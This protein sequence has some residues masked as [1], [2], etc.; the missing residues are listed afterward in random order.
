[1][2]NYF[3]NSDIRFN[4]AFL[5]NLKDKTIQFRHLIIILVLL[6]IIAFVLFS[7]RE[8][9]FTIKGE[10]ETLSI[11]LSTDSINQW[12]VSNAQIVTDILSSDSNKTIL[13]LDSY[14]FPSKN[15]VARLQVIQSES[16]PYFLITLN[17]ETATSVGKIETSLGVTK[18]PDYVELKIPINSP[19]TL[20]FKG[21]VRIGE[22]VGVGVDKILLSGGVRIIEKQLFKDNRY[23]AGE[24]EFD[25]GDKL[26]L[27]LDYEESILAS[28]TGFIR[29][30][31]SNVINF[32]VQGEGK[33]LKVNKLGSEGYQI[34]S[35]IWARI[36]KDPI[37]AALT[38]LFATLFLLMEFVDLLIRFALSY[39]KGNDEKN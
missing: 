11:S 22:D 12:D 39:K 36:T 1:M 30:S 34:R 23:I 21:K 5:N 38:T 19:L 29:V 20:P 27:F 25:S 10:T 4:P 16:N 32:T 17:S 15:V 24:F 2:K 6:L 8:N 33:V 13:S 3:L 28:V 14:F 18:L 26:E 7:E 37:V 9:V 35:N 31:T